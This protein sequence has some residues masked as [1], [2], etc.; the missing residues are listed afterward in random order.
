MASDKDPQNRKRGAP[1][2]SLRFQVMAIM[3]ICYLFPATLLG[4]FTQTVL[5]K[6]LR[7]KTETALLTGADHAWTMT[8]QRVERAISL[9]RDVIY[10]GELADAYEAWHTGNSAD[11]EFM[12][13]SRGYIERK[14]SREDLF[15]FAAFFPLTDPD[16]YIYTRSGYR[17][18]MTF[19]SGL[20]EEILRLGE[21]ID[22]DDR[23]VYREGRFYLVRN[24]L[25]LGMKRYGMLVLGIDGDA[26]FEPLLTLAASWQSRPLIRL[27][28]GGDTGTDWDGLPQ[29]LSEKGNDIRL[30]RRVK[31]DGYDLDM[32]ITLD[33]RVQYR[34]IDL[35]FR[36]VLVIYL[37]LIPVLILLAWYVRRRIVK[38]ISLLSDASRR[39]E[40]GELGVTVPMRGGDELG[41]LGRA[42]S[43]MSTRIQGLIQKTYKEEIA[44]KDAQI[45][46]LQ[47]R[48]NPHFI[49]N[50]LESINWEARIEGSETI[51]AMVSALSVL[52]GAS[53]ARQD[54]RMVT[55]REETEV[56]EAY[57]Y[58]VQQRFGD[59]LKVIRETDES[60]MDCLVPLLTVQP[61]LENAVEHGIAPAGGG[62]IEM[63]YLKTGRCLRIEIINT[64]K[65]IGP[66]DR[67]KID[68]ALR[69]ETTAGTHLGLANIADRLRLIY[70][71]QAAIE[72]SS[73][74][75][76]RT[77]VRMDVPQDMD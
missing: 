30:V 44:L 39:I 53:M 22:T 60:A 67:K 32:M 16:I 19:V 40:S 77:V 31:G 34:Q 9:A 52:L 43:N 8:E 75:K 13:L 25:D 47:S 18:A 76:D 70:S 21:E 71:G 1:F 48:I 3:L 17:E 35:F 50:A 14:Y 45:Q 61:V 68:A 72:V 24:L 38:P 5:M 12:R 36:L 42:F 66:E 6:S 15:T 74:E 55:M 29:G 54:R 46:A 33:R 64:G 69:G 11:A 57:I 62:I 49:N 59:S 65:P 58:F 37:A 56:A 10:D 73:D 63:R 27:D 26:M 28:G 7:D 20:Q 23:F 41:D 2:R 4:V 51:P